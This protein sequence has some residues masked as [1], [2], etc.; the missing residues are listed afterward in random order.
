[1]ERVGQIDQT[2]FDMDRALTALE[3]EG[4]TGFFDSTFGSSLG[5]PRRQ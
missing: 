3:G 4:L 2:L 5:Q 1:M